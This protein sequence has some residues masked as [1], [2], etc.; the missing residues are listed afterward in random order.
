LICG[1]DAMDI[2]VLL[3]Y[4]NVYC[5]ATQCGLK[6]VFTLKDGVLHVITRYNVVVTWTSQTARIHKVWAVVGALAG[7]LIV[8]LKST[9]V[10][11]A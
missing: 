9:Y 7:L 3:F 1:L 10:P 5:R 6:C 8:A 2:R 11:H 4:P